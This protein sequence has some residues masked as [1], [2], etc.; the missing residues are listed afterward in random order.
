[1][2]VVAVLFIYTECEKGNGSDT[3]SEAKQAEQTDHLILPNMPECKADVIQDHRRLFN[4]F[5][6]PVT[7]QSCQKRKRKFRELTPTEM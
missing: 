5:F 7:I 6:H 2:T 3:G 1:M 4:H